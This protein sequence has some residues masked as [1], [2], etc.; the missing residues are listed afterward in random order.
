MALFSYIGLDPRGVERKGQI[1]ADS[2]KD[3]VRLLKERSFFVLKIVEGEQ[4]YADSDW[5]A[6]LRAVWKY[7]APRQYM[8]VGAMDLVLLFRR[9]AMM[10]R[11]GYTLVTALEACTEMT[12]KYRLR[13]SLVRMTDEIRR[14][15]S[16]SAMLAKEKQL[17]SPLVANLVASGEKSGNVDAVLDRLADGMERSREVKFQLFSALVYP[18]LVLLVSVGVILFLVYWVMPKFAR[19]LEGRGSA[20]PN[21]TQMLLDISGWLLENGKYIGIG[22][23]VTVFFL[24]AAYTFRGGKKVIDRVMLS[25]P[26]IGKAILYAAMAQATWILAMLLTSGVTVLDALRVLSGVVGNLA[27][28]DSFDDAADG[29]LEG[30]ALSKSLDQPHIPL[31]VR[32]MAAVGES[33]GQLDT[34][35]ENVGS[36]YQ[37]ELAAKVKMITMMIEPSLILTVGAIVGFVY[38]SFFEAVMAVSKGGM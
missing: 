24:L 35:M 26:I 14:G 27:V 16:F 9:V 15:A 4:V 32:H 17:F 3:A 10:L 8:P 6:R 1:E 23:G 12:V 30:R 29:L 19:F 36:F 7:I 13:R 28:A 33:S 5:K 37:K 31:M 20:L 22:L 38:Y 21:S 25:L 18:G 11:A 2:E 34:V